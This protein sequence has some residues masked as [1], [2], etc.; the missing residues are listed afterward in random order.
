M[1]KFMGALIV[2]AACG[3]IGVTV[4]QHYTQRPK[5]LRALQASLQML[6]TEI[7]YGATPLAEAMEAVGRGCEGK[8]GQI[9]LNSS[10][11]LCSHSGVTAGE[12]WLLAL[13]KH[14]Y[15]LPLTRDDLDILRRVGSFL[16]GSDREDQRKHLQLIREQ[17]KHQVFK[18][19]EASQKSGRLW[20]SLGFLF[21]LVVVLMVY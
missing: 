4:A 10:E 2:V 3:G 8:L 15:D 6:E 7:V 11:L 1:L 19:D 17:I 20:N 9:F 13:E 18:A 14:A 12:A 16:G 5:Y 21:G